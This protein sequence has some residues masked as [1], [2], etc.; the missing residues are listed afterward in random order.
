MQFSSF[1]VIWIY[2]SYFESFISLQ[3]WNIMTGKIWG[4]FTSKFR[5]LDWSI[6]RAHWSLVW[7]VS[8]TKKYVSITVQH[9]NWIPVLERVPTLVL[10]ESP[11]V[12]LTVT[13]D[14][15]WSDG[16]KR[17]IKKNMDPTIS[18]V[19]W[20][21]EFHRACQILN[22]VNIRTSR[23]PLYRLGGEGAE[24]KTHLSDY[25]ANSLLSGISMEQPGSLLHPRIRTT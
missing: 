23:H 15:R 11:A 2:V 16:Q 21:A 12:K 25:E 13:K 9:H 10:R 5:Y 24:G 3:Y 18:C 7:L 22:L 17:L 8:N 20:I 1:S 4:K 14:L 19:Y 6:L